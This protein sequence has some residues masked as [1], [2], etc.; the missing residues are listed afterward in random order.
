VVQLGGKDGPLNGT[1]NWRKSLPRMVVSDNE[2]CAPE[3]ED[4]KVPNAVVKVHAPTMDSVS[5]SNWNVPVT[6]NVAGLGLQDGKAQTATPVKC[7]VTTS[8]GSAAAEAG[9]SRVQSAARPR[10]QFTQRDERRLGMG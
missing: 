7:R 4:E 3:S 2:A 8:A 6:L 10:M 1:M 5:G 9:H